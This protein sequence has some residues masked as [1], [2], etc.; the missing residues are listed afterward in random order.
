MSI[1]S[2]TSARTVR[3]QRSAK[4]FA[5]GLRGGIFTTSIPAPDSTASNPARPANSGRWALEVS[6][7]AGGLTRLAD[8]PPVVGTGTPGMGAP[9]TVAPGRGALSLGPRGFAALYAG[10]PVATLRLAGL[11]AGG[12]AATDD[13]LGSVFR[14]PAFM[15]DSF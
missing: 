3:T 6:G 11:I 14:G 8:A 5:F 9:S 13:A 7:G 15:L 4:A 1:R 12:D 10:V 2:V